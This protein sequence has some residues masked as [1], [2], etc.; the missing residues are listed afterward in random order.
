MLHFGRL[1]A[2]ENRD[3]VVRLLP[4]IH[5]FVAGRAQLGERKIRVLDL[6]FLQAGDVGLSAREPIEQVR[7][8]HPAAN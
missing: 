5:R 6:G 1:R 3:A 8:A 4:A 7:Q 2:R